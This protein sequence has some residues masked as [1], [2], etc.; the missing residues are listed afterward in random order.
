MSSFVHIML[1]EKTG[2]HVTI[3]VSTKTGKIERYG[4]S[5]ESI[6]AFILTF[7]FFIQDNEVSIRKLV[8]H[9]DNL[10]VSPRK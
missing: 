7:R 9:Y 5:E 1:Y 10:K 6:Y 8:E 2:I 3:D 4:P